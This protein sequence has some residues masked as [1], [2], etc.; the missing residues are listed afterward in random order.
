MKIQLL[1]KQ[2]EVNNNGENPIYIRLRK[3]SKQGIRTESRIKTEIYIHS[4][5]FKNGGISSSSPKYAEYTNII[6][7]CYKEIYRVIG[8]V[9]EEG[10]EPNPSLVKARYFDRI[11][12][13]EE[14]TPKATT[15][16][17]CFSEFYSTKRNKSKGYI[18][19]L[20]TLKNRLND[21]EVYSGRKITFDLIIGKP[22]FFKDELVNFFWEQLDLSNGYI[23]KLLANL[24][25]F[26]HY[27]NYNGYINKKP[28]LSK[29]PDIDRDEKVY[30]KVDEVQDYFIGLIGIIQRKRILVRTLILY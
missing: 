6:S 17:D 26:L 5:Y 23:N 7:N 4:K 20:K 11:G 29:I 15:F 30:L 9:K 8:E 22:T 12:S 25:N 13:K 14:F 27:A 2:N 28:I 16:W 3:T 1:L 18:K 10:L 19:T 21:Y 24:S